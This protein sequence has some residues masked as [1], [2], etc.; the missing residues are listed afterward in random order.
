MR[1]I[2]HTVVRS[3]VVNMARRSSLIWWLSHPPPAPRANL[4]EQAGGFE[5]RNIPEIS[6]RYIDMQIPGTVEYLLKV[7][8]AAE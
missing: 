3:V 2:L 5:P 6:E 8:K 4:P 7:D 1:L